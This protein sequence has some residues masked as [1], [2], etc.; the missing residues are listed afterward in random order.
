MQ[1]LYPI[2]WRI[3]HR[4]ARDQAPENTRAAFD[5][6]LDYPIDGI[7]LDVRMSA[8]DAPVIFHDD[9]LRRVTGRRTP[10][11][12]LSLTQLEGLDWG[13]WY[14]PNFSG[15][16]LLTLAQTLAWFG[17]RTR[18][19]I[20]IKST[21]A[22][23]RNG[24]AARL[25]RRVIDLLAGMPQSVPAD[26]IFILSFDPRVLRL[27]HELA[28]QWR[29]VINAPEFSPHWVM[30]LPPD[31]TAYLWAIDVR[32][33]RLSP[34]LAGWA[35]ARGL[36]VFTYTCNGPR[37]VHKALRLGVDAVLSDRPGWLTHFLDNIKS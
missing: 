24:H 28:P 19:M 29:Y 5:R 1:R 34:V 36:R 23:Q 35:K 14:H 11:E 30:A 21:P 16:P 22:H 18:L 13:G 6:A 37:Q 27:A 26:H 15:E 10:L 17:P 7:E 2:P 12:E 8:D 25:T 20:E 4:G 33:G 3:A 9:T 31:Q 32:I